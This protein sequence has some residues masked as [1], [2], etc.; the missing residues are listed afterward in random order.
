MERKVAGKY[1][2]GSQSTKYREVASSRTE[3]LKL[4]KIGKPFHPSPNGIRMSK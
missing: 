2:L 1:R 4:H 3:V